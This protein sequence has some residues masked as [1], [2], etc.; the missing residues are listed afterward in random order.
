M[1][2]INVVYPTIMATADAQHKKLKKPAKCGFFAQVT[3]II[4]GQ[5]RISP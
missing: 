5:I 1:Y 2:D 3:I 4:L